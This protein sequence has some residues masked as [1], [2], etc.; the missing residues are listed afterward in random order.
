[1]FA[2]V[3]FLLAILAA[4]CSRARTDGATTSPQ[5]TETS[6]TADKVGYALDD[7]DDTND[8][9]E[10]DLGCPVT[11]AADDDLSPEASDAA[12]EGALVQ[13]P[14]DDATYAVRDDLGPSHGHPRAEEQP[15]RA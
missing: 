1:M 13:P 12:S 6:S 11:Y 9:D 10:I 7:D 15:P 8:D 3:F 5:V 2:I 14:P 4:G